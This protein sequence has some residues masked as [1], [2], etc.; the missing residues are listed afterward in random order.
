MDDKGDGS[1]DESDGEFNLQDWV[2][3]LEREKN[4]EFEFDEEI[5]ENSNTLND[6]THFTNNSN[7][8]WDLLTLFKINA[9]IELLF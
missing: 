7:A 5:D 2:E 8:K 1:D 4:S 3:M 9:S 6:I